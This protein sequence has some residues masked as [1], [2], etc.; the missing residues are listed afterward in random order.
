M[1]VHYSM[2]LCVYACIFFPV[3]VR[4]YNMF[5]CLIGY[6]GSF[7][8][9]CANFCIRY[10]VYVCVYEFIHA[11]ARGTM[12]QPVTARSSMQH[13]VTHVAARVSVDFRVAA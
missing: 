10:C 7:V 4:P 11:T 5:E 8:C 3:C 2:G 9:L 13:Y 6:L 12:Q 1:C